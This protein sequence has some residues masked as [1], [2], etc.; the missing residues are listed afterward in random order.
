MNKVTKLG[1]IV[2]KRIRCI[3]QENSLVSSYTVK[4]YKVHH[5]TCNNNIEN[6]LDRNFNQEE[7]M[8]VVVSNLHMLMLITNGIIYAL[9]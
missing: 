8:K 1:H 2:N 7:R 6:K 4:L 9:C 3:M 5:T